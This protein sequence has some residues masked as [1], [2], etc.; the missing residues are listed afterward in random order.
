MK[1]ALSCENQ[2]IGGHGLLGKHNINKKEFRAITCLIPFLSFED[3]AS[4]RC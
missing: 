4:K 1:F 3:K 2:K